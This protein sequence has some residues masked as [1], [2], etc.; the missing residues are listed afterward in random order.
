MSELMAESTDAGFGL[1]VE[2]AM[3]AAQLVGAGIAAAGKATVGAGEARGVGPDGGL[4]AC[5]GLAVTGI[6]EVDV[7]D[8][9]VMVKVETGEVEA[10]CLQFAQSG[11]DGLAEVA[12]LVAAGIES[13]GSGERH[14]GAYHE[15]G[16]EL[17]VRYLAVVVACGKLDVAVLKIFFVEPVVVI[18]LGVGHGELGVAVLEQHD[19]VVPGACAGEEGAAVF[20][21]EFGIFHAGSGIACEAGVLEV[22]EQF[23]VLGGC[24]HVHASALHHLPLT[25]FVAFHEPF[26]PGIGDIAEEFIATAEPSGLVCF[27]R[28]G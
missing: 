17:A 4:E 25:G 6:D 18:L 12:V 10:V 20:G 11:A 2:I 24:L 26:A 16:G 19:E 27:T 15:V 9:T 3:A 5:V 23:N 14:H 22:L 21:A 8:L 28:P 13:G 1:V 7:V